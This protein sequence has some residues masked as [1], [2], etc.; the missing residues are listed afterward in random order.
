M[1]GSVREDFET[2]MIWFVVEIKVKV[3]LYISGEG[4]A[5]ACTE[6][7]IPYLVNQ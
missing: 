6:C 2:K 7:P 1:K 3:W 4:Y 5:I